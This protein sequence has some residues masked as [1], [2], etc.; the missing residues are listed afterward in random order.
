MSLN[1]GLKPIKWRKDRKKK[2]E[3]VHI[4]QTSK[5]ILIT[6][7]SNFQVGG[8]FLVLWIPLSF[9]VNLTLNS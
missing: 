3:A 1:K 5:Q 7:C 6:I 4:K 9:K 2:K 8:S